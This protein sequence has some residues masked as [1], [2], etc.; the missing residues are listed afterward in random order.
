MP[1]LLFLLLVASAAS[2]DDAATTPRF[3]YDLSNNHGLPPELKSADPVTRARV[4]ALV[5]SFD[6]R[7]ELSSSEGGVLAELKKLLGDIRGNGDDSHCWDRLWGGRCGGNDHHARQQ[8]DRMARSVPERWWPAHSA[9]APL[10]FTFYYSNSPSFAD[11]MV[12]HARHAITNARRGVSKLIS[13]PVVLKLEGMSDSLV[14]HF[15]NNVAAAPGTRYLEVG[16]F[17][18]STLVSALKYNEAVVDS[19]VAIDTWWNLHPT[20][21]G[22]T[23]DGQESLRHCIAA[24]EE[25]FISRGGSVTI[26]RGDF[27][28]PDLDWAAVEENAR[29]ASIGK[30][31]TFNTY[32]YD[33]PHGEIDHYN[34]LKGMLPKLESTFIF[35]VDDFNLPGVSA[36][37]FR[38]I[39]ELGLVVA[40]GDVLGGGR[41][42]NVD[43]AWH[44]GFWV[45]VLHQV[46]PT[47]ATES[48]SMVVGSMVT[49]GSITAAAGT[50][51]V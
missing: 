9:P 4:E 41:D 10:P 40:W 38:A 2:D 21:A 46:R 17:R 28:S 11:D 25:H 8:I 7:R 24:V 35:M 6:L 5:S 18:G 39:E 37:T 50:L 51:T 12:E 44:N 43:G 1:H 47:F 3:I 27:R 33:G 30:A 42:G 23:Y 29:A 36:G 13:S 45:A 15:L 22:V 49:L 31:G 48:A 14:R 32:L 19:A 34:A 20:D 16:T 26:L